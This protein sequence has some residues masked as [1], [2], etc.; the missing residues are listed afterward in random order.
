[1][2]DRNNYSTVVAITLLTC[3]CIGGIVLTD[4]VIAQEN[5]HEEEEDS[6]GTTIID[7][8]SLAELLESLLDEFTDLSSSWDAT[9]GEVLKAVFFEPFQFI[10]QRL[11]EYVSILLSYTPSVEGNEA[12]EEVHRET[13]FITYLIAGLGFVLIGLLYIAGPVLGVTYQ[14][15]RKSLPQLVIALIF[16]TISIHLLQLAIDFTNALTLAFKPSQ[17]TMEFSQVAGITT[18]LVIVWV[19]KAVLL[20]AVVIMYIIRNVLILFLVAVSPLIAV[21]WAIPQ[22]RKYA[23]GF[24]SLFWVLMAIAPANMLVLKFV[25]AML[26]FSV[27]SP[28]QS[29]SNWVYGVSALVLILFIPYHL[30]GIS[31]TVFTPASDFAVR[32]VD[33]ADQRFTNRPPG[34]SDVF[35]DGDKHRGR[36]PASRKIGRYRGDRR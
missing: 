8:S 11:V 9:L 15:A 16:A 13:L 28:L 24:I 19:V 18:G 1:M 25:F 10:A 35:E 2:I 23:N 7:F 3:A 20:L 5:E 12:V 29:I 17:L 21:C 30:Y 31:R 34:D 27:T 32:V 14:E 22:T 36:R 26:D 33:R 6:G 4:V